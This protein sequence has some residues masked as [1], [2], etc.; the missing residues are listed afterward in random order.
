[1]PIDV[2]MPR[3]SDTMEEG[4]LLKWLKHPGDKVSKGDAI[5][6]VETDKANME[7]EAFDEGTL[8]EILIQEGQSAPVGQPIARL[9][10]ANEQRS[11]E[12][13]A[14]PPEAESENITSAE[15]QA[16]STTQ[17]EQKAG[18]QADTK[19]AET[20]RAE[21]AKTPEEK[22]QEQP[23]ETLKTTEKKP[24][25][26][27]ATEEEETSAEPIAETQEK[28]A[29]KEA[30]EILPPSKRREK[31]LDKEQP[32]IQATQERIAASPRARKLAEQEGIDLRQIQGSGPEGRIV[33][34]D[35]QTVLAK[36]RD[37]SETS[38]TTE[39]P[40]AQGTSVQD[41]SR[42]RRTIAERMID[43]KQHIPHFY[44]TTVVRADSLVR[45]RE[46]LNQQSE[47][48]RISYNDLILKACA[49]ALRRHPRLNASYRDG[50]IHWNES[51]NIAMAVTVPDGLI[52][53]VIPDTD[54]LSLR[55]IAEHSH[56][57]A[58]RARTNA[59]QSEDLTGGTFTVSNMG[60]YPVESFFAIINP[61][62][63][64][65]LAVGAIQQV[66]VVENGAIIPGHELRLQLSADHR[67]INGVEAAEFMQSIQYFLEN[68]ALLSNEEAPG[69][70][71]SS[72]E[73]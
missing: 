43:S 69:L 63:A 15:A 32:D 41:L 52:T 6:E 54:E 62:Q 2:V 51:V 65:I 56:E 50:Q 39:T 42:M 21:Q 70:R 9:T 73:H 1:M 53:P 61:P 22:S 10:G 28:P 23:K 45:I 3:L 24:T 14:A 30:A 44:V 31:Y 46:Q 25:K 33:E 47:Q 64:A 27:A 19:Q 66:P 37:H 18:R 26:S 57:V 29:T 67:I 49:L 13:G 36:Q 58:A 72:H 59:L 11:T 68:P 4:T 8:D 5:A 48:T 55:E 12:T 40:S 35:I 16:K 60:M 34:E 17:A 7:V 71:A 20:P 38:V